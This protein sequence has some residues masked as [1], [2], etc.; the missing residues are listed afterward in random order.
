MERPGS[1]GVH[2]PDCIIIGAAKCGTT[3]LYCTLK[4]L[5]G[6][7]P[8][9]VKAPNFFLDKAT[10][11]RG[12]WSNG[13]EWYRSL[14]HEGPGIKVDA[15][16]DYS[17]AFDNTVVIRRIY[18]TNPNVRF[19]YLVRNPVH[20]SISHYLHNV[21]QGS[22]WRLIDEAL[23]GAERSNYRDVS[24]Y[25]HQLN[26][27]I[28]YFPVDRFC[29][30]IS[31]SFWSRPKPALCKILHFF[32]IDCQCISFPEVRPRNRT[33]DKIVAALN[34]DEQ[35]DA[36]VALLAAV[37][38]HQ[39]TITSTAIDIAEA[40]GFDSQKQRSLTAF[41]RDDLRQFQTLIEE[42]VFEWHCSFSGDRPMCSEI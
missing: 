33:A 14:F 4:L 20:R 9:K 28:K 16:T 37:A 2:I 6:I 36:Q 39:L 8:C 31:E 32:G 26:Q 34:S 11:G 18:E 13:L 1:S 25:G 10:H 12:T 38:D 17:K 23:L 19:I 41:F 40:L 35:N 27:F 15:S 42:E 5:P 29:V 30:V 22:E 7:N 24:L 21:L 3:S